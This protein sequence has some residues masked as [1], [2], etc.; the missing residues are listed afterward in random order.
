MMKTIRTT[1]LILLL[2]SSFSGF[3]QTGALTGKLIDEKNNALD[4]A[5]VAVIKAAD[6]SFVAGAMTDG[7]G[8]FSI[9]TPVQGN[10]LMRYSFIGFIEIF[11]EQFTVT[12][13]DFSKNFG[14]IILKQDPKTLKDVT[15]KTQRPSI[16]QM[17]DRL[18]VNVQGTA[19]AA[20]STAFDVLARSPGVFVDHEGNI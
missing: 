2:V 20:G 14:N 8:R 18:V 7:E 4:F 11:S 3:A 15:I 16:I 12:G 19:L 10:Y 9:I 17:S 13:N 6:S 5:N 1:I